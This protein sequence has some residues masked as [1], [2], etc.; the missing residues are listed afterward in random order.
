MQNDPRG[1]P[2]S[3][4]NADAVTQFNHAVDGLLH[5]K[6]DVGDRVKAA[7]AA[8][9]DFVMGHVLR[10]HL[11]LGFYN[12]ALLPSVGRSLASAEA[13]RPGATEREQLHIDVLAALH[14]G[15][16][17]E[18]GRRYDALLE[19]HP[20]DLL[21]LRLS[22]GNYFWQG[23][24][25]NLRDC[26]TRVLPHWDEQVPGQHFLLGMLAFGQE[27]CG[28][29][30]EAERNGRAAV[31]RDPQDHWATHAVAHVMEM[32]GRHKDGI[33]WLG[34]H[35]TRWTG[36][37][38][39]VFHL[40]WH[41]AL[42]HLE[43]EQFGE[44]LR[45]YDEEIRREP[46]DFYLDLQNA[47]SLLWRLELLGLEVGGRWE[48]LAEQSAQHIQDQALPFND[49]HYVMALLRAGRVQEAEQLVEALR[50]FSMQG[51]RNHAAS[52]AEVTLPVCEALLAWHQQDY[53]TA[54]ARLGP[55]STTL[56]RTGG[57][58]AQRDVIAQTLVEA[59]LR[60][61]QME[62][63]REMLQERTQARPTSA[64]AWRKLAFALESSNNPTGADHAR[65]RA[66]SLVRTDL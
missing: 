63:A 49:L 46:S 23:D 13:L 9:P 34:S 8:D 66:E 55:V 51:G 30:E 58:H 40:W 21:A 18:A 47:I 7:L 24:R 22:H 15:E 48:E 4:D 11:L 52:V 35:Q 27:E 3:T 6:L 44:V 41:K 42:F 45:L 36:H 60:A 1:L 16:R 59:T 2:L 20:H 37:N 31:E 62:Q 29:Y 54:A 26:V 43:Q 25:E 39:F 61:G 32:Q 14:G 5:Y 57:S 56:Y 10:G 12:N 50:S 17:V 28:Q 65:A 19:K 64:N 38:N 53:A 33:A